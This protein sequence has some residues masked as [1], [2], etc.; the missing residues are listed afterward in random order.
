MSMNVKSPGPPF[1]FGVNYKCDLPPQSCKIYSDPTLCCVKFTLTLPFWEGKKL[2]KK[3]MNFSGPPPLLK[4]ECSL[5]GIKIEITAKFPAS[6][7]V[8]DT[9][10]IRVVFL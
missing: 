1:I 6:R 10:R 8:E 3:L 9:K 2:M 4:N 7:H 5:M